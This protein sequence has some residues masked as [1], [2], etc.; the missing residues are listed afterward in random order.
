MSS[1]VFSISACCSSPSPTAR[2]FLSCF[3][4]FPLARLRCCTHGWAR[5]SFLRWTQASSSSTCARRPAPA[6]KTPR[7]CAIKSTHAI[8]REIPKSELV[9]I[10]DNIG[11]P[12]SGLNL[13]YTST[14]VVSAADAD[15]TVALSRKAPSHRSLCAGSARQAGSRVPRRY[16]LHLARGYGDADS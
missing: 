5:I 9:S 7:S 12:Y 11:I 2:F 13:S 10:I 4:S 16:L 6:S 14:G 8:R 1:F 3:S 15:I